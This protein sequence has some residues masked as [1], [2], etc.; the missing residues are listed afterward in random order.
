MPSSI[1]TVPSAPVGEARAPPSDLQRHGRCPWR[2]SWAR[3]ASRDPTT[4]R[5]SHPAPKALPGMY[6][7]PRR[8]STSGP[9]TLPARASRARAP[10]RATG[11]PRTG[12]RTR[13]GRR[14]RA[15]SAGRRRSSPSTAASRSGCS[16]APAAARIAAP[17]TAV[18]SIA[19][20]ADGHAEDVRL[21]P[22]PGVVVA[23]PAGEPELAQR[24]ACLDQRLGDVAQ[25]ERGRL[26]H[27]T[28]EVRAPVTQRQADER[29]R[30]PARRT[31]APARRRGRAGTRGRSRRPGRRPRPRPARPWSSR[32]RRP[33][34]TSRPRRRSRPSPRPRPSGRAAAPARGTGP[35]PR[36]RDPC[37]CRSRPRCRPC[38]PRHP[39][40]AA[41]RRASSPCR[42]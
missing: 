38:R 34:G 41:R 27:G 25:R 14:D 19:G 12:R 4:G 15:R 6:H 28:G 40:A 20:I 9:A 7:R 30:A 31:P 5:E 33:R 8:S 2:R 22:R 18:L 13:R 37:R 32:D 36:P 35:A 21:D 23:R 3:P 1:R 16:P 29:A 26:E 39:A 24:R 17:S 10:G 42:R 11:R